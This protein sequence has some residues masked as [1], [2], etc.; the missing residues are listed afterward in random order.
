MYSAEARQ[1]DFWVGEWEVYNPQGRRVGSS[2]IQSVA[3]GCGIL[4]NWTDG[5]GGTGKSI[6]FY[7]P[8]EHKWFQYWVGQNGSPSRYSGVYRDGALRY[9][10]ESNVIN[11]QK[12][13]P[14]LTF[15]NV[16]ANT[17]RQFAEKSDDEGKTWTTV[18][19]FKYIRK[20]QN[21]R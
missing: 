12:T 11:G 19:D 6:N 21:K 10:G 7:D 20:P 16:D 18:Y 13:I 4:E 14:R 15:F 2:V 9:V 3:S 17:V 5:F 8:G 1:F